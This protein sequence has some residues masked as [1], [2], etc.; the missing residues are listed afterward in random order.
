[1]NYR[2]KLWKPR[3]AAKTIGPL[4]KDCTLAI[5]T[6]DDA[7]TVFNLRGEPEQVVREIRRRFGPEIAVLTMGGEGG[8]VWD[9]ATLLFEPGY[10]LRGVIDRLGA[11]DAFS[12]G[13]I[14]GYLKNDL[15]LGLR[16]GIATSAMKLGMRGDYFWSSLAEVEEVIRSK[17][18]DVRR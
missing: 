11:G 5:M 6:R 14:Y 7:A 10:P 1:V 4:L 18:G 3:A 17:G 15:M 9:G 13:M 2:S 8:L 16:F 12:A